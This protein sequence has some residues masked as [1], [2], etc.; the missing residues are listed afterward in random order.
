VRY[1][2]EIG[3]GRPVRLGAAL[4]PVTQCAERDPVAR[5]KFLL[6]QSECAPQCLHA[7]HPSR[8]PQFFRRHRPRI[9]VGRGG[10]RDLRP[11]IGRIGLFGNGRSLPSPSA[12]T[13]V[14]SARIFAVGVVLLMS[15]CPSGRDDPGQVAAFRIGHM[16]NHTLAHVYQIDPFLAV[17]L[18]VID[19]F[20]RQRISDALIASWNETPWSRQLDGLSIVPS[21]FVILHMY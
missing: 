16:Q 3:A 17:I 1:D 15:C 18:A 10:R 19:P 2:R 14:P 5:G 21:K 6:G 11:V 13:T 9:G 8:R 7:R 20:D 12:S 4:F